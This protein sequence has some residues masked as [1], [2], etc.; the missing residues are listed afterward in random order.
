MLSRT[1]NYSLTNVYNYGIQKPF[2]YECKFKAIKPY[3]TR[4]ES[5]SA[6]IGKIIQF[7]CLK[8]M[9]QNENVLTTQALA[10]NSISVY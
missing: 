10:L 9:K 2:F 5:K 3:D 7:L 4:E 1:N 6:R 8:Q